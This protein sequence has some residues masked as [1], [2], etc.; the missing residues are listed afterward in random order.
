MAD[1]QG[2]SLRFVHRAPGEVPVMARPGDE[3]AARAGS[4]GYLRASH[5]D[6]EQVIETLKTAFVHGRLARG[7]FDQRAGQ[8]LA[9]RTYAELAAATVGLPAGLTTPDPPVPARAQ[10]RRPV[11]RPGRVALAA[12]VLYAGVWVYAILFPAGGD[13]DRDGELIFAAGFVY[14]IVLAI[15]AGQAAALLEKRSSGQSPRVPVRPPA[16]S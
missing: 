1:S 14:L 4:R 3:I 12:T 15:C 16:A 8:A 9:A 5:A 10:G 7:E 6:R 11:L 13:N 2:T